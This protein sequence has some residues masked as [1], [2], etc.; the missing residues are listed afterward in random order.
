[1]VSPTLSNTPLSFAQGVRPNR[2]EISPLPIPC[3]AQPPYRWCSAQQHSRYNHWQIPG[4]GFHHHVYSGVQALSRREL[5]VTLLAQG[6]RVSLLAIVGQPQRSPHLALL[7][8]C[9]GHMR[10]PTTNLTVTCTR[11]ASSC[12]KEPGLVVGG[13]DSGHAALDRRVTV[14]TLFAF[15]HVISS[16]SMA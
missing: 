5:Q 13:G 8:L 1:M 12:R 9:P 16:Q 4:N 15:I 11:C 7:A 6:G 14:I 3:W 10:A 2:P